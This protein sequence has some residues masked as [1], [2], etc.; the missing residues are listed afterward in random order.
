[1]QKKT[2]TIRVY[3]IQKQLLTK[4]FGSVQKFFDEKFKE[5]FGEIKK[6]TR[7]TLKKKS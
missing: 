5:Q 4:L 7:V 2:T 1:M 6:E 3:D